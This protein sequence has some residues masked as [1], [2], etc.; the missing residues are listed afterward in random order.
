[1]QNWAW[2]VLTGNVSKR[3]AIWKCIARR[4]EIDA[5]N[6]LTNLW[7]ILTFWFFNQGQSLKIMF[8]FIILITVRLPVK[9]EKSVTGLN[10]S[11]LIFGFSFFSF[12]FKLITTKYVYACKSL[13]IL[14]ASIGKQ[15][16]I[17]FSTGIYIY[18][19]VV[20]E[21]RSKLIWRPHNFMD[22]INLYCLTP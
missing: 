21:E 20:V 13:C 1:M 6:Q 5:L 11:C 16:T 19:P 15:P 7:N 22:Y 3:F 17:T 4:G 10:F 8:F 2:S 18:I 14:K 9:W 12:F